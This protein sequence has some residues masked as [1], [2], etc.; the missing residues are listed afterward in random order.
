ML[1]SC[2][3]YVKQNK[4]EKIFNTHKY[5]IFAPFL[6]VICVYFTHVYPILRHWKCVRLQYCFFF[7]K[8]PRSI[9]VHVAGRV[10]GGVIPVRSQEKKKINTHTYACFAPFPLFFP[11]VYVNSTTLK[12]CRN[13]IIA[14]FFS[15]NICALPE[16]STWQAV[17]WVADR[18]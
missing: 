11:H 10:V 17:W 18:L 16:T 3:L 7:V 5:V 14:W 4:K 8:Y 9:N 13:K 1:V 15:W 6:R 2:M 12:G